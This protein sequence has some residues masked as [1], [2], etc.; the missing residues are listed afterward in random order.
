MSGPG[1]SVPQKAGLSGLPNK[2]QR[3]ASSSCTH[4]TPAGLPCGMPGIG[5]VIDGAVQQAA[6]PDRQEKT[7]S[8]GAECSAAGQAW[9]VRLKSGMGKAHGPRDASVQPQR[10][11]CGH[12]AV[13]HAMNT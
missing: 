9:R 10:S 6:Q 1:F 5:E 3:S 2:R 4:G 12:R 7:V 11:D 13:M 8:T